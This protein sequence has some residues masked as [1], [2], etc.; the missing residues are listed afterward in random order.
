MHAPASQPRSLEPPWELGVLELELPLLVRFRGASTEMSVLLRSGL[1]WRHK[2]NPARCRE[3]QQK[4]ALRESVGRVAGVYLAR[5]RCAPA[6]GPRPGPFPGECFLTR[7][8][9]MEVVL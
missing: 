9:E 2:H 4:P 3:R 6:L 5:M 1:L 8:G 7:A